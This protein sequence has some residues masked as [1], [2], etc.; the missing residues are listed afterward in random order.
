M[1]QIENIDCYKKNDEKLS[2]AG[3]PTETELNLIADEGFEVVINIRPESE[4]LDLFDEKKIVENL[5]LIYFQLPVTLDTI[6]RKIILK[7]FELMEQQKGRKIF[8]HCRKN[9]RVSILLALYQIIKLGWDKDD[10]FIEL[11]E[12]VEVNPMLME[13][14]HE[15]ISYFIDK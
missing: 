11:T 9:V 13:F 4:M 2:T 14:I 6:N 5:G 3:Q 12:M 1:N 7:F 15:Q 8:L 10:A